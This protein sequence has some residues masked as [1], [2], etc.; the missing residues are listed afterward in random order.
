MKKLLSVFCGGDG[1]SLFIIPDKLRRIRI[2]DR[3]ADIVQLHVRCLQQLLGAVKFEITEDDRER[4]TD[5]GF[6]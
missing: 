6:E 3:I 4:F 1:I 2:P 5:R